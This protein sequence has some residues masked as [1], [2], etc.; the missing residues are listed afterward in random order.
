MAKKKD[1][2]KDP[3]KVCNHEHVI[4]IETAML[5][6][7]K[8]SREVEQMII[9]EGWEKV[10]YVTLLKHMKDHV[11]EKRELILKYLYEK[12]AIIE[13][14]VELGEDAEVDEQ[15]IRLGALKNLDRSI[16]EANILVRQASQAIQEQ[17][18]LRVETADEAKGKYGKSKVVG[19]DRKESDKKKAFVPLQSSLVQLYKVASEELRQTTKTKIEML[20]IDS[21]SRKAT[22]METLVDIVMAQSKYEEDEAE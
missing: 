17:L 15:S 5:I 4:E 6:E 18:A 11:D 13:A 19:V 10:S 7:K 14:Q 16:Y 1:K 3:C 9:D 20:G 21:E 2:H 8:S 22:S 12:K